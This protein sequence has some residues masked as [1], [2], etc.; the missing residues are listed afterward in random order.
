MRSYEEMADNILEK[1][2][3]RLEQKKRRKAIIMRTAV[4]LSGLCAAAI[5]GLFIW[6]DTALRNGID[7]DHGGESIISEI[8]TTLP[9]NITT[10]A[11]TVTTASSSVAAAKTS[12]SSPVTS[13]TLRPHS[14]VSVTASSAVGN[15]RTSVT[16]SGVSAPAVTAVVTTVTEAEGSE[17]AYE[18]SFYMKKFTAFMSAFTMTMSAVVP[19]VHAEYF[20]KPINYSR[21]KEGI[22][23]IEEYKMPVDLDRNGKFDLMDAC[24]L[25]RVIYVED[26]ISP[27]ILQLL[28]DDPE[29]KALY[30]S[31]HVTSCMDCSQETREYIEANADYT[32]D[33]FL[34]DDDIETLICYYFLNNEVKY[35][36]INPKTY[37]PSFSGS[38]NTTIPQPTSEW[39]FAENVNDVIQ[40]LKIEHYLIEDMVNQGVIDLDVNGDNKVNIDDYA[41]L[42][43]KGENEYGIQAVPVEGGFDLIQRQNVFALPDEI[44]KK[45][46]DIYLARPFLSFESDDNGN[47]WNFMDGLTKYFA[48][49]MNMLPD[50]FEDDFYKHIL[51]NP[52]DYDLGFDLKSA[53]VETGIIEEY[54]YFDMDI[55]EFE[56]GFKKYFED[57]MNGRQPAP[58]INKD[59][60]TDKFD[61]QLAS[62]YITEL[63]Q[64]HDENTI[65]MPVDVWKY[66]NTDFDLNNNGTSGDIYD[67]FYLQTFVIICEDEPDFSEP[68]QLFRYNSG[69]HIIA[70]ADVERNGDANTDGNVSMADAVLIMQSYANP[71]K[72]QLTEKGSFNGDICNT[73]DGITPKDAQ[74][75]QKKMLGL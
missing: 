75:I 2:N 45:C 24:L 16:N 41:Y 39:M 60:K 55:T 44:E 62:K 11:N 54:N 31:M 12:S 23:N 6:H 35:D 43:I 73:G 61:Y 38:F 10:A 63:V 22:S 47:V 42:K 9:E 30:E 32:K 18:R 25:E 28:E 36:D 74:E 46:T 59:G 20:I 34:S 53:A 4:S 19:D 1:Y 37:D 14:D 69:F 40:H 51:S 50:Y 64:K 3:A 27:E 8:S 29:S 21:Y 70:D 33:G 65:T 58:D 13:T 17:L 68:E 57:V 67:I 56:T 48:T 71:Q 7:N 26:E 72:Y 66:L 15:S 52:V 49:H 5:V